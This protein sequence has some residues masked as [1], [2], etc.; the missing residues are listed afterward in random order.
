MRSSIVAGILLCSVTICNLLASPVSENG[1]LKRQ[2]S[3]IVGAHGKEVQLAGP[4]L[5]WSIWGGQNYYT[6]GA[7]T[8]VAADWN[9]SLIRAAIAVENAGGYLEKPAQQITYAKSVI[10]AAIANGIYILVDWH[11]HNANLHIPEAKNFFS[12]LAEAYKNTPNVIWEIWNEPDNTSGTGTNGAD[13]WDDIRNYADSILPVIR[14]HSSNLIVVGTPNWSA[15]P[16]TAAAN[17]LNDSNVAY[18]L[19]FYAGTHGAS[20]RKNAESAMSKGA[21]VFITEF[22]TTDASGG[23]TD[24]TLFFDETKTWLDWADFNGI[25]WAN[26][27]L[28]AINEPCS[29]LNSGA[30]TTGVWTDSDLSTSGKWIRGRLLSRPASQTTDTAVILTAVQ[31]KGSITLSPA[32]TRVIKGTQITFTAVPLSGWVFKS[33]DGASSSID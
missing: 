8:T 5:Y 1:A 32:G 12:Q 18:A 9:A 22:G 28:S 17:P 15:D 30:S 3:K 4:S 31:G 11:D 10:D 29:E 27:S 13:T 25:S 6:N 16:A 21:A 23:K 14:Q 19:H 24:S 20:V 2:G 26:W 7:V 33:W